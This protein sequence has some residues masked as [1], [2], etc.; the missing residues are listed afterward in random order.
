VTPPQTP[1]DRDPAEERRSKLIGRA[2]IVG[3]GLLALLYVI[4]TFRNGR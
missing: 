4:V 1:P 3:L 2:M